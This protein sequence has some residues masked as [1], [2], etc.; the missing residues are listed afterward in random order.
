[1]IEVK[2]DHKLKFPPI[3][4]P[5]YSEDIE[6]PEIYKQSVIEGAMVPLL[7]FN[8]IVITFE[9]VRYMKLSCN[10]T[11]SIVVEI[12]DFMDLVTLL[13]QPDR[14]NV[15]YLQILPPFDDAYKKIQLSFYI[16]KTKKNGKNITLIGKYYIPGLF[17]AY[18]K[19]YGI[20]ST[21]DLFDQVSNELSMG[22]CSNVDGTQDER[23]IYNPNKKIDELLDQ[24]VTFAGNNGDNE[25]DKKHVFS[26]W[27]DFWNNINLVDLYKEYGEIVDEE[28]MYIWISNDF[29]NTDSIP[30]PIRAVAAFSNNP[31]MVGNPLYIT[32]YTPRLNTT[33]VTDMVFETFAMKEQKASAVLIQDGDVHNDIFKDYVYGGEVFGDFDYLSQ[34]ACRN[35]FLS[36]IHSQYIEI[37]SELPLLGLMKG[38]HVN[39]WWYD[40]NKP[41]KSPGDDKNI[42]T[43]APVPDS[44]SAEI[45]DPDLKI[46][47]NKTVSGQYYIVDIVYEYLGH[48]Q[49]DV[50]YILSRSADGIQRL[51]E[52][53]NETFMS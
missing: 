3:K 29:K 39:L 31:L 16:T 34:R 11:P 15:L 18:M 49:W 23:Y 9:M 28:D 45:N 47:L 17:D 44:E 32:E 43:N 36:K 41:L 51:Q 30:E 37:H 21:Y 10:P 33:E 12:E 5:M 27:I 24:E 7:K 48:M 1:M 42:S 46:S 40:I 53:T 38:G 22:F 52:H 2:H 13:D 20:I 50:K 19:P 14:D 4:V 26:W 8:N 35:M 6:A 25:D